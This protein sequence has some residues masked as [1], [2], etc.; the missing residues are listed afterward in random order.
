M[1]KK[2]HTTRYLKTERCTDQAIIAFNDQVGQIARVH[3]WGLH[4]QIH[5]K[6]P[7]AQYRAHS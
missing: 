5:K 6:G 2:R 3:Q 7:K 4:N 1:F